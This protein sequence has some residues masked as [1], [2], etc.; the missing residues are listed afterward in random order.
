[1]MIH[2]CWDICYVVNKH[3]IYIYMNWFLSFAHGLCARHPGE[4]AKGIKAEWTSAHPCST[5]DEHMMPKKAYHINIVSTLKIGP[6]TS[7]SS[8]KIGK[9][10]AEWILRHKICSQKNST[11]SFF[12]FPNQHFQV[13]KQMEVL[14]SSC[15]AYWEKNSPTVSRWHL[16]GSLVMLLKWG[17]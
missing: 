6:V 13:T 14:C 2:E 8:S 7:R 4:E 1:M 10:M 5:F 3:I 9:L 11:A 12:S 15:S 16:S 17:W